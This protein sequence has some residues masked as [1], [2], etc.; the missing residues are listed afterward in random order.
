MCVCVLKEKR[1]GERG[2]TGSGSLDPCETQTKAEAGVTAISPLPY[3][4]SLSWLPWLP[5]LP[6]TPP[7]PH[8]S[9]FPPPPPPC[10]AILD[11]IEVYDEAD[12]YM[13]EKYKYFHSL[14]L[15]LLDRL[16]EKE[17]TLSQLHKVLHPSEQQLV[18]N[19]ASS[20]MV[21]MHACMHVPCGIPHACMSHAGVLMHA[22]CNR[23]RACMH[24]APCNCM[25]ACVR[26]AAEHRRP[27]PAAMQA[28]FRGIDMEFFSH[29]LMYS[30]VK[31]S[32]MGRRFLAFNRSTDDR[33][34][35]VRNP[36][37]GYR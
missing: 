13:E 35:S 12:R 8:A 27:S 7:D 23:M 29:D 2:K 37:L 18:I 32:W 15:A 26:H 4:F 6:A 33:S 34:V 28:A 19:D 1:W 14:N 3:L 31:S 25:R 24:L 36:K 20:T 5:S 10:S 16:Q 30:Y 11:E 9:P 21:R 17:L 22:P